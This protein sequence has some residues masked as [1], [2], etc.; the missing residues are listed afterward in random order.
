ML[1]AGTLRAGEK[2]LNWRVCSHLRVQ[3]PPINFQRDEKNAVKNWEKLDPTDPR[4]STFLEVSASKQDGELHSEEEYLDSYASGWLNGVVADLPT[5]L[6]IPRPEGAAQF[7][8][9]EVVQ[10]IDAEKAKAA[11]KP[12]SLALALCKKCGLAAV[13]P[14]TTGVCPF[15]SDMFETKKEIDKREQLAEEKRAAEAESSASGSGRQRGAPRVASNPPAGPSMDDKAVGKVRVEGMDARA[16]RR[17]PQQPQTEK[18]Y[19]R[20]ML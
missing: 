14:G 2:Q 13:E 15:C 16:R 11:P 5:L 7:T 9:S 12:K 17:R 1:A 6:E 4:R 8:W 3:D 18:V 10:H 20:K 19:G